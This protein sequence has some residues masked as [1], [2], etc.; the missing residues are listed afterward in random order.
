MCYLRANENAGD[1]R[2]LNPNPLYTI[3]NFLNGP[4]NNIYF[5][6]KPLKGLLVLFPGWLSHEAIPSNYDN[7]IRTCI[8]FNYYK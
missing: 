2:F 3:T 7:C 1:L 8:A 4:Q 5:S 6:I